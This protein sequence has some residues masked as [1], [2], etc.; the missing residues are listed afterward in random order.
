MANGNQENVNKL[1]GIQW[2]VTGLALV[3]L[4]LR[5]YCKHTLGRG[6]WWDDHLLIAAWVCLLAN[7][8]LVTEAISHGL[9][10]HIA[11]IDR[12]TL[13][14]LLQPSTHAGLFS[15]MAAALS[16]T[17]FAATLLRLMP[18]TWQR[19]SIWFIIVSINAIMGLSGLSL[20]IQCSPVARVWN[21]TIPGTCWPAHRQTTFGMISGG[22]SSAMDF[23]L[24][25]LPSVLLWNLQ[26]ERREKLGVVFA[27]SLGALAGCTGIVKVVYLKK[28]DKSDF[29][30]F[31]AD[32]KICTAVESAT[33]IMAACV[34]VFRVLL[35][36]ALTHYQSSRNDLP[37][38]YRL[39]SMYKNTVVISSRQL[40]SGVGNR[41]DQSDR[42]ILGSSKALGILETH[43]VEIQLNDRSEG[44]I[45]NC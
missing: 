6:F 36:K 4:V 24:A 3:F 19:I 14:L 38:S 10:R 44:E 33:S 22:Y 29:T 15:V 13:P 11:D 25:L 7:C 9:G 8:A 23:I 27:M 26:M 34:P 30:F 20:Y 43:E 28:K 40:K 21:R 31:V 41:D 2:V 45:S 35:K 5:L 1:A 16:K 42:S 12:T 39:G 18:G 32:L 17:S 37:Q